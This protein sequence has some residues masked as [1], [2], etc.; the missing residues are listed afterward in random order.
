MKDNRCWLADNLPANQAA[1]DIFV[2][3][4]MLDLGI[5]GGID[6]VGSK[7]MFVDFVK[8]NFATAKL[9]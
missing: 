2:Q 4:G 7:G 6:E 3:T 8:A 5:S 9:R 1:S